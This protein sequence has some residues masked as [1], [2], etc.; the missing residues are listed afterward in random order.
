MVY[1]MTF[2]RYELKYLLNKKEKEEILLAMKPHMKLDDYGRTVIRNI[3]FDTE[4]FRLIRRSLEKPVYKEKLRIRSYKPVQIT[5]PVF[6]EIKKKYK[7][8]VYKRRL[9]LPEKTVMESFR[10]GEPLPV[11][12][13]IGDEIQYFREYYKNLQLS[14]FLSY[15]R[16]AFYSLDGSDFRVTFDENILY[17]R[18]D[19]SLGSEIYGHPLLGKQ[20][21]LMEIKTSGGI[22]LWMSETLT[23]HHLYKTSFS[24]YGSAYQRMMEAAMQGEYCY[25]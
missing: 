1:Q 2:K 21:T 3:Y 5:D 19:I 8:V 25:A 24:K 9:L 12:S 18:N 14:V 6:V 22:P 10:T 16:E 11:C 23:K 17:R 7:S 15:E 13:Q 4:N 20:Q